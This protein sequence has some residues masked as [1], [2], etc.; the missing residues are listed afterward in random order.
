MD[1]RVSVGVWSAGY[2]C[3]PARSHR[4]TCH[5]LIEKEMPYILIPDLRAVALIRLCRDGWGKADD[6]ETDVTITEAWGG[7]ASFT[8]FTM[9]FETEKHLI[10]RALHLQFHDTAWWK[11]LGTQYLHPFNGILRYNRKES[12]PVVRCL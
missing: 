1:D 9:R 8:I 2:G 6:N 4:R 11:T 12:S 10:L 7:G 5:K 3:K